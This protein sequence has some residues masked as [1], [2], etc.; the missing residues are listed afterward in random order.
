[1]VTRRKF[2]SQAAAA[3]A[4]SGVLAFSRNVAGA[5]Q[6]AGVRPLRILILGGTGNIGP[7]HVRA[8]IARGHHVSVFSR[9]RSAAEL[10]AG[11][12]HLIGDRNNDLTSIRGRDWDGVIDIATYG[13]GWVRTLG[14]ALQGRVGLYTFISTVS[15]YDHPAA[16]RITD[17]TSPV[18]AYH[19]HADP[20]SITTEGPDYGALKIL[21]EQEA[22]KQF[23]GRTLI[24]RPA[25]IAGPGDTH[26]Y[27][28]YWL[29]RAQR[30]GE[31]LAV[32]DPSTPVQFI[33][34]RDLAEWVIRMTERRA[35]GIYNAAGPVPP[36]D[37]NGLIEAARA[38]SSPP[39][40]VTWVSASWLSTR[41]DADLFGGLLFWELNRGALSNI[42]NARAL[43]Q[44]LTTR[45]AGVTMRDEWQ[46]LQQ[47][48]A[49]TTVFAGFRRKP[50]GGFEPLTV[51][52]PTYLGHE[53]MLLTAWHSQRRHAAELTTRATL[54]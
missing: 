15:V 33:D 48:P 28:Y 42:S 30:G 31:I 20:Y 39:P 32:G 51:P 6:A 18:L 46:W 9:G 45:S 50:D 35:T 22:R 17:E 26:P 40:T 21:C 10:P 16:N 38:T 19:G 41:K 3:S 8:A 53:K 44:G 1:M 11:V 54:V 37:L 4:A 29:L 13:P 34:V 52:W 36:T 27:I 43:A 12:E 2:L 49:Q 25:S 23:P 7:Y 14:E 47:Q 24:A 5:V